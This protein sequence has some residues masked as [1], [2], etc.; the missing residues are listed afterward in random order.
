MVPLWKPNLSASNLLWT[1][2]KPS[3]PNERVNETELS[4]ELREAVARDKHNTRLR[5]M[6]WWTIEQ[7]NNSEMEGYGN[8]GNHI[9]LDYIH[10]MWKVMLKFLTNGNEIVYNCHRWHGSFVG[11]C[12]QRATRTIEHG[13]M[14]FKILINWYKS[15]H[16]TST[17]LSHVRVLKEWYWW[18]LC[19]I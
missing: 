7:L 18:M 13:V 6:R 15:D 11:Y 12:Y 14:S 19:Y 10:V 16:L 8:I 3:S 5:G 1:P 2:T 4:I 17:V 9:S